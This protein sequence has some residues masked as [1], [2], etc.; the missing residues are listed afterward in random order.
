M[1]ASVLPEPLLQ[2][3]QAPQ[4]QRLTLRSSPIGIFTAIVAFGVDVAE[5][6]L[7]DYKLGYCTSNILRNRES[8][9]L[10]QTPLL[11]TLEDVGEDCPAWRMWSDQY[12]T[13][14]GIYVGFAVLFGIIAGGVTMTTKA[15]LPAAEQHH[16]K[17]HVDVDHEKPQ[18]KS[19]YMAAGSGIPE[20]KTILSGMSLPLPLTSWP[21]GS[22]S[23]KRALASETKLSPYFFEAVT[24]CSCI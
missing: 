5:A 1:S 14:Y 19:M 7:A 13:S 16:D 22:Q 4:T 8:C 2:I 24:L 23:C 11:G 15:N 3:S 20:I 21:I 9:C 6:T 17:D 12:W 10:N 18:G